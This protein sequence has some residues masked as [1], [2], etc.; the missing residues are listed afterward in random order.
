MSSLFKWILSI[1]KDATIRL[2]GAALAGAVVLW[3]AARDI[4]LEERFHDLLNWL[5]AS[6]RRGAAILVGAI[7]GLA[8]LGG[9]SV[10]VARWRSRRGYPSAPIVRQIRLLAREIETVC[11]APVPMP[12]AETVLARF[13]DQYAELITFP[14]LAPLVLTLANETDQY[15]IACA[16]GSTIE[17]LAEQHHAS[18]LAALTQLREQTAWVVDGVANADP[19]PQARASLPI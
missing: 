13:R 6:E 16:P 15:L 2:L 9:V 17:A 8:V 14:R 4:R 5:G 7:V 10:V 12:A 3:L 19:A 18:A 1:L 11:L